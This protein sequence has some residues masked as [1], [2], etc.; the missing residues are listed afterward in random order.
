M[1]ATTLLYANSFR[2]MLGLEQ[3]QT[4]NEMAE[5]VLVLRDAV[6][7]VTLEYTTM[8][9]STLVKQADIVLN[10]FPLRYTDEYSPQNALSDL[11]YVCCNNSVFPSKVLAHVD[12]NSC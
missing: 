7:D 9:G 8:N 3:N 12:I 5:S 1:M 4:W 6:A 10:T 11:D 2:Q